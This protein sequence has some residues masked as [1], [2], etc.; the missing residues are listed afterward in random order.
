M[1]DENRIQLIHL[2]TARDELKKAWVHYRL[3]EG[4]EESHKIM[5][6]IESIDKLIDAPVIDKDAEI[7][8]EVLEALAK[9]GKNAA[10]RLY[11]SRTGHSLR[12][13]MYFVENL[14][15]KG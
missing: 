14:Q 5:K 2:E 13:S 8:K 11:R 3:P 1:I 10:I 9:E 7:K 15:R 4:N 6:M 12:E